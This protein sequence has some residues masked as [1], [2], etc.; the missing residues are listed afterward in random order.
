MMVQS[1]NKILLK[2]LIGAAWI[3]GTIQAEERSYLKGMAK[4]QGLDQDPEIHAL[5]SELVPV[6]P[7]QCHTWIQ[8][9]LGS[10]PNSAACQDLLEAISGLVYS[11]NN[12]ETEEAKLINRIQRLDPACNLEQPN[13]NAI[14][15]S[16]QRLYRHWVGDR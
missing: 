5:L 16:V 8:E 12:I 13:P 6:K 4:T 14:L 1:R 2:I 10:H 7:E 9:Y 15:Q 3:D 11:D